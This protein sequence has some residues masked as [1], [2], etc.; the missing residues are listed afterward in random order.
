[1]RPISDWRVFAGL[2]LGAALA[3]A[4]SIRPGEPLPAEFGPG[5]AAPYGRLQADCAGRLEELVIHYIS[6]AAPVVG[7]TYRDFLQA[8]PAD[9]AVWVI[10]PSEAD[11]ADLAQRVGTAGCRLRPLV[12]GHAV[13][14]WSRDR[15]LAFRPGGDTGAVTLLAPRAEDAAAVWPARLGDQRTP[16][17]LATRLAG[18]DA[19][20][21]WL[22]FD[23]GDFVS[24]GETV[25]VSP[26]VIRRNVGLGV[27]DAAGLSAALGRLLGCRVVLLAGG[28]EHHAGMVLMPAGRGRVVVGDPLLAARMY[29]AARRPPPEFADLSAAT[30]Q[31]FDAVAVACRQAGYRVTRIPVVPGRDGRTYLTY[32]NVI[33]D[34]RGGDRV[35][36]MPTYAGADDLNDAAASVWRD[37]G[38]TVR[39]VDC[40][41]TFRHFGSLRC[42]VNVLR[43]G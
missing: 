37:L 26:Q 42:L 16:G 14:A 29:A 30:Q 38:F 28:P 3:G 41:T 8:L 32:L 40:S 35:V 27:N 31:A 1:M 39:R 34:E 9:V 21:S 5:P 7:G 12:V 10:C 23:G 17:D 15:W 4:V 2:L 25:W 6:E 33:I 18:V 19:A 22:L 24:D 36:Y 11:F 43:R 20:R 13:T